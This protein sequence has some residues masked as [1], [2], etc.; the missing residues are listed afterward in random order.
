MKTGY[1]RLAT[2]GDVGNLSSMI[3]EVLKH[4]EM[5]HPDPEVVGCRYSLD[6]TVDAYERV[7]RDETDPRDLPS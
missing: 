6:A 4:P 2:P 7:Y 1:G 5:Y 3:V